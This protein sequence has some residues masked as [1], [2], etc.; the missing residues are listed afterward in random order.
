[1]NSAGELSNYTLVLTVKKWAI[2]VKHVLYISDKQHTPTHFIKFVSFKHMNGELHSIYS[3]KVP[4][5]RTNR[6]TAKES[7][8][9]SRNSQQWSKQ[10]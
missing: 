3:Q 2:I 1:M 6:N 9:Q 4:S 7:N 8:V 10:D 5:L